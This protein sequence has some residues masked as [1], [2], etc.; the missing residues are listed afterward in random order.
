V[1]MIKEIAHGEILSEILA[2]EVFLLHLFIHG[3]TPI[4]RRT[5]ILKDFQDGLVN[6]LIT[7]VILDQ[8]IDIPNIDVLI[9]A[10]GGASK[11]KSLQR[12]GRGL[13]INEG[14]E[15]LLV[16]D[17]AD[18]TH[19]YLAKHSYE[20]LNSYSGEECFSIDLMDGT[21]ISQFQK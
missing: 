4:E 17:F 1:V 14:K 13:R 6:I 21:Y 10:G 2:K 12:I 8:G 19:R 15:N 16:I 18:R 11:I 9:L 3:S 7:S 5:E 20:R